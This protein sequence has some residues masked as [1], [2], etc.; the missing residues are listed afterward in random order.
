MQKAKTHESGRILLIEDDE[1][2]AVVLSY[3]LSNKGY[4]VQWHQ[5]PNEALE[6]A[7][8]QEFHLVLLDIM[9]NAEEDGFDLCRHL[10][11][12]ER[13]KAI[14]VIMVT[15]RAAIQDR[16]TGLRS[17]ADDYIIKPFSQEELL[18]RVETVLRRKQLYEFNERYRALLEN[19]NDLVLFLDLTGHIQQTNQPAQLQLAEFLHGKLDANLLDFFDDD[20][21]DHIKPLFER[22]AAGFDVTGNSWRLKSGLNMENVDV[23]LAP[24]SQSGRITGMGC[25]LRDT[26]HRERTLQSMQSSAQDMRKQV[27]L[28]H[29]QIGELQSKLILAEKMA[30]MGQLA[31]GIAHELR[32]PLSIISASFYYL[33]R[34]SAPLTEKSA[35][36]FHIIEAEIQRSQRIISNLLDFSRKSEPGRT[37]VDVQA[38]L[39]QILSLVKKELAIHDILVRKEYQNIPPCYVNADDIKQIFLNLVLNAKEAMPYGGRLIVRG[40]GEESCALIEFS[41]TGIGIPDE[42]RDK[43]FDP[44]FTSRKDGQGTGLGLAIVHSAVQRNQGKIDFTSVANR[45][46]TF[47]IQLPIYQKIPPHRSESS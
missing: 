4:T 7:Q 8:S 45:G 44:F 16:V 30:T 21:C 39:D 26:T 37:E 11:S 33:Q 46:A 13:L 31:A 1:D 3:F 20:L 29:A 19:S 34:I 9:L 42:I 5:T 38:L 23:R 32:N 25:I 15:A 10:K 27:E 6:A 35:E 24:L 17:G 40:R 22:V 36:H 18:A 2:Q 14:P 12:D 47:R 28:S 41:D 43:V